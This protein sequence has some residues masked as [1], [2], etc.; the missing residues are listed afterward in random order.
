M[1]S[2]LKALS[3]SRKAVVLGIAIIGLVVLAALR[4]IDADKFVDA[5]KWIISFWFGAHAYEEGKKID[6]ASKYKAEIS[7][8]SEIPVDFEEALE[9]A[10]AEEDE[11][12]EDESTESKE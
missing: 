2:T 12:V 10:A 1:I 11:E 9:E 6:L 8:D 4:V 7:I 5:M 3:D